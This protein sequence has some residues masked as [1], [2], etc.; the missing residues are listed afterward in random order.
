MSEQLHPDILGSLSDER[1]TV[2]DQL[3]CALGIFPSTTALNQPVEVLLLLQNLTDRPLPLQL[4]IKTPTHDPTGGRANVFTPKPRLAITLPA[5]EVGML[6]VPVTPLLPTIPG[7]DFPVLVHIGIQKPETY[8]RIRPVAGGLQP[9]LLAISPF[10]VAVLREIKFSAR[11]FDAH[12]LGVT[13]DILPGNFPPRNDEPM[14]RYESLWT[15]RNLEQEQSKAR[16]V[17]GEALRFARTLARTN[18]YQPLLARTED[19]FGDSGIPLHPGEAIYIA[20]M[21]VY[22]MENGLDLEPGF[23]LADGHWFQRLCYLLA[24]DPDVLQNVDHL[25]NLLYTAVIQD[26]ALVAFSMVTHDTR[27]DFGDKQEQIEYVGRLVAALEGR[28]PLALEHVYVPLIMGG[29]L[30]AAR[31]IL[32]AEKPWDSLDQLKEAHSG[33]ESLAGAAFKEVFGILDKLI[34]KTERVLWEM[35]IPR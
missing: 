12:Q 16:E 27:A 11:T 10:R 22:V 1:M 34:E 7:S 3:Q 8:H 30:L 14:P 28:V 35:R 2:G 15:V 9:N 25:I 5:A 19:L 33:R 17:A 24:N 21:L 31:V 6:H 20:R 18:V 29:M 26:A 23:A 13:F 32:P 4:T